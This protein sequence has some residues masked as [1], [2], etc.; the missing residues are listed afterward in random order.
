M[1]RGNQGIVDMF[2]QEF[3][4]GGGL[5]QSAGRVEAFDLNGRRNKPH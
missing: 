4:S 1:V 3:V 2:D 5:Y